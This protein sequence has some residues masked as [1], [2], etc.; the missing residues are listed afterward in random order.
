MALRIL[1]LFTLLAFFSLESKA[2]SDSSLLV[3]DFEKLVTLC[4]DRT[5]TL[6]IEGQDEPRFYKRAASHILYVGLDSASSW[7]RTTN[8]D[9]TED[10]D[11][12]DAF[13]LDLMQQLDSLNNFK[14]FGYFKEKEDEFEWHVLELAHGD[15]E[16]PEFLYLG[17]LKLEEKFALGDIDSN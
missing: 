4:F 2:Q 6:K 11:I 12:V 13:C 10:Q 8:Y 7:T 16:N 5:D 14:V 17:F 9:S 1:Y 3:N 15:M